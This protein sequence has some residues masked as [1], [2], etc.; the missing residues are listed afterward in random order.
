MV[1]DAGDRHEDVPA[2][3]GERV[4]LSRGLSTRLLVLTVLFMTLA[5]MLIFMPSL[6]N[7][8]LSWLEERLSTAAAVGVVLVE[9]DPASLSQEVQDEL[10]VGLGA[11]A[12]AVRDEGEARL[13]VAVDMPQEIDLHV[14]LDSLSPL[15]EMHEALYTLLLGGDRVLRV[16]GPVGAGD[17]EFELVMS[18]AGLRKAML[19]YARNVALLS[20]V[21]S[22]FTATLV[23]YAID[24]VMIRPMRSITRSMLA[25]AEAPDDPARIIRAGT[26]AD[27][28][29][30][31]APVMPGALG[32]HPIG[33][34]GGRRKRKGREGQEYSA[35]VPTKPRSCWR[36]T[37]HIRRSR[38]M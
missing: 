37:I 16:F 27:A 7:F 8:R 28:D 24:R 38:R 32:D 5:E 15:G 34:V 17:R 23:F 10:L 33:C 29:V 31:A 30:E 35:H 22:A 4:P 26:R 25:F 36:A 2:R 11:M 20:L 3:T 9:S 13:L 14:D 18:E 21:L 12:L 6:A 19:A 1:Q